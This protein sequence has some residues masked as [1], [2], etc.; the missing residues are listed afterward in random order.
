MKHF[1]PTWRSTASAEVVSG[2]R[3]EK[4][5]IDTTQK[6]KTASSPDYSRK[7]CSGAL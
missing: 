6:G 4:R 1:P 2:T 3:M 5:I 7:F